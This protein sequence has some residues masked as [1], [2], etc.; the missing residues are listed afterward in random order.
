LNVGTGNE[1][2]RVR[3][4]ER[5]LGNLPAGGRILDAGAG[6]RQF[7]RFC[8]HLDYVAQDFGQYDGGGDAA[9]LQTGKWDRSGLDIVSD[10]AAIPE[11][12]ASFDAIMC[13][14]VLEHV[15][16]PLAALREFAR[17]LRPKGHLV[18]TAP[19]CSLTHF[20]PYH[21][22]SGF[23]RYFYERHLPALGFEVLELVPNGN[24][25]EYLAQEVRR[26]PSVAAR[27]ADDRPGRIERFG[28]ARVLR[29][30]ERMSGRD[31]GSDELLCFGY[32]VLARKGG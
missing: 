17:L 9:A 5:T 15:P 12:D 30:L 11:P 18:L 6:E 8:G 21:F 23:N 26:I 25:F 16:D 2:T 19:F 3:W 13:T 4:L 7:K 28:V 24:F 1:A 29:M 31:R 14:E 32:H 27:Y 22:A 20:S 10:I